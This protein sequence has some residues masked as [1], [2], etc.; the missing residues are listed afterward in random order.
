MKCSRASKKTIIRQEGGA[1]V[2]A[3]ERAGRH[4]E[5][6]RRPLQPAPVEAQR[7]VVVEPVLAEDVNHLGARVTFPR[8]AG[9]GVAQGAAPFGD[10]SAAPRPV[11][12]RGG[13]VDQHALAVEAA[14]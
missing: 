13:P 2:A 1:D 14:D 3:A 6:R 12:R 10:E 9:Q 4:P 8:R 5:P 7:P 11:G